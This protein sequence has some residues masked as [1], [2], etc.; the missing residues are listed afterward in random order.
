[1]NYNKAIEVIEIK[2]EQLLEDLI[3][4]NVYKSPKTEDRLTA[5]CLGREYLNEKVKKEKFK[6]LNR[7][8]TSIIETEVQNE[9]GI[10]E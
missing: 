1:M 9:G 10:N 2:I 3:N 7:V 4:D 8:N 6:T 5:L